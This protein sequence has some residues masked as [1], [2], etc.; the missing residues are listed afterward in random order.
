MKSTALLFLIA[1]TVGAVLGL[2]TLKAKDQISEILD[3]PR[4]AVV[5]LNSVVKANEIQILVEGKSGDAI[6]PEAERFAKRLKEE[7]AALEKDC[8]CVL[9]VSSAVISAA[10]LPDYTD[11]LANK[12]GLSLEKQ[13]NQLRRIGSSL[14]SGAKP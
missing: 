10:K 12:L 3:R 9:L 4:F 2:G 14:H 6:L 13:S 5:N 7:L 8:E 11:H 1:G